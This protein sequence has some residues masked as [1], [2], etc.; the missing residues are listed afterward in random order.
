[1]LWSRWLFDTANALPPG[2]DRDYLF[3]QVYIGKLPW[4][5][6]PDP[7]RRTERTECFGLR[8]LFARCGFSEATSGREF[9]QP[10]S[11]LSA[12]FQQEALEGPAG[13]VVQA[14]AE[15]QAE[16]VQFQDEADNRKSIKRSASGAA[17]GPTPPPQD[18]KPAG[19][20]RK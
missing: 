4:R 10:F 1:M 19:G 13:R 8:A 5:T 17:A 3:E 11:S 16:L 12:A 18:G 15:I 2:P 6:H 7:K 9:Q 20:K 14:L